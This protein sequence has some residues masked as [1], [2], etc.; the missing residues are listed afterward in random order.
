MTRFETG[1]FYT[2]ERDYKVNETKYEVIKRTA[3]T[4]TISDGIVTKKCRIC[5]TLSEFYGGE[6]IF[7]WGKYV[8]AP[9]IKAN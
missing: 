2:E 4:V 3:K 6:V 7:P 9:M 8:T 1:K 5:D